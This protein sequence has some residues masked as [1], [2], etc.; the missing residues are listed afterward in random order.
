MGGWTLVALTLVVYALAARRLDRLS[1]TAPIVLVVSGTVLGAGYLD[2]LPA[3]PD[4]ET[5][6]LV[7]E[8][9]LALILF[10]DAST[11]Q[12]RQAEGDLGLPTRLLGIGLPLTIALGAGVARLVFPSISWAEA[13]LVSA[14]LAPTDAALG[15]AVVTNPVVPARVRRALNLE[16]GLNDG[17]ATP[18]V[19]VLLA[20]VVAGAAHQGWGADSVLELV[21]G[22]GIGIVVGT[23]GGW[24]LRRAQ[25]AQWTTSVSEQL[26]VLG[27]AL[28]AYGTAVGWSGNGFVAAFV[29]GLAFGAASRG[30]LEP[31][32]EFADTVGLFSSFVVWIIFGAAFVG[33]VLQA[34]IH[35]RALLY[36]VLSLTV[37]RMLPVAVA[38]T[39][40]KLRRDT[41]GFMAWFGPRGLASVVFTLIAFDALGGH[42]LARTLTEVTTCTI[43]LSV[44]AHGLTSGPLAA[45]YG[46]RIAAAPTDTPERADVAPPR[47]R[48]R[49][50]L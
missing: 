23:A 6:R 48:K 47:I 31:A 13:A 35:A 8:L 44:L 14:I 5:V 30:R 25:A 20:V 36:A 42:S 32:T 28:L 33:P 50:L 46:R 45:W 38:L 19:S 15:V 39:G 11:I 41:V 18:F 49:S 12:L 9:T 2:V 3:N 21:R 4:T 10:A 16:S 27:L 1:V 26:A 7:T 43:L 37:V 17:I 22:A 40:A 34:G 29:A 24:I